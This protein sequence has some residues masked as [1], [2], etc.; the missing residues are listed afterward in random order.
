[1]LL[2]NDLINSFPT[3]EIKVARTVIVTTIAAAKNEIVKLPP[4]MERQTK[5]ILTIQEHLNIYHYIHLI[6]SLSPIL[7][8]QFCNLVF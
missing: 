3:V 1:M 6:F 5:L 2:K 8:I 4:V 7:L